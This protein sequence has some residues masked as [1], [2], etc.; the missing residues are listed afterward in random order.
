MNRFVA[1]AAAGFA[2]AV[3]S[4]CT[5][6]AQ[7]SDPAKIEQTI[8]AQ[9]AAW[10]ADYQKKDLE[11]LA[12]QYADDAAMA[13]PGEAL[14][15]SEG[16]RRKSLQGLIS[17]PNFKLDF[18][19]D[20]VLVAK[21]GDLATSRGHYTLTMTDKATNKPATGTGSYLTVYQKQADG[22]W[23]AVEDFITPGPAP[24]AS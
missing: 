2:A 14:A 10:L 6:A 20:R 3:I 16:Q 23:K 13:G 24:A 17:D 18:A 19:S 12:G 22:S 15:T 21:S 9:E 5:P 1:F 4:G 8:R 7:A 11:G